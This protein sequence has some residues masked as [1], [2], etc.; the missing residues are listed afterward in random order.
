MGLRI[1][2]RLQWICPIN[3]PQALLRHSWRWG[4]RPAL[5]FECGLV[6]LGWG[7]RPF[8][9]KKDQD[10]VGKASAVADLWA[11]ANEGGHTVGPPSSV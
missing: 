2:V 10:E 4:A 7:S 8:P 6:D 9:I 11:L 5:G 1:S 3:L